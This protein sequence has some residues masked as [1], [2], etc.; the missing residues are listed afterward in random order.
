[1]RNKSVWLFSIVF[2]LFSLQISFAQKVYVKGQIVDQA[3]NSPMIGVGVLFINPVDTV[4]KLGNA[5]D[6]D[7]N[8]KIENVTSGKYKIKMSYIGYDTKEIEINVQDQVLDLGVIK[9]KQ[10][11]VLLKEVVVEGRQVRAIQKGDT[12]EYNA[13]AF[14]TKPDATVQDLVTKMPGVTLENGT[15]KAQGEAIKKVLIDGKEYFGEDA[16]IA[17]KN[18]PADIVDKV[19]IF[20]RMSDQA[21]FS[22]FDDGNSQKALNISTKNGMNKGDFGKIYAGYGTNDRYSTGINL[23]NFKGVRK[24]SLIGISNNINQQ[25]FASQDL[26]GVLGSSG[27]NRGGGQGVNRNNPANNF[28][29]GSQSGIT[30]T[31]SL[32]LNYSNEI[33]KKLSLTGSYFFNNANNTTQSLKERTYFL[34]N[35]ANQLYDETSEGSNNNFNHRFNS[36]L[37]YKIDSSNTIIITPKIS[38]Q[39]NRSINILSGLNSLTSTNLLSQIISNSNSTSNGYDLSNDLLFRHKFAKNNRTVSANVTIN[40]NN[41]TS[42]ISQYSQNRFYFPKDSISIIDQFTYTASK[43]STLSSNIIYTEPVGKMGS[44]MFNYSPTFNKNNSDRIT[45]AYDSIFN[46]YTKPNTILSNRFDNTTITQRTGLGYR[47]GNKVFNFMLNANYQNVQMESSQLY[48]TSLTVKR[49]FDNVLPMGMFNYKFSQSKNLRMFY[50]SSTNVPTITQLQ[51]VINNSNP[52]LLSVGN[53]DLKQEFSNFLMIRYGQTN[54]EKATSFQV[55]TNLTYTSNYIGTSTTIA[56]QNTVLSDQVVLNRGSQLSQPV[57]LDGYIATNTF[58]TYGMLIGKLKSNLNWSIGHLYNRSPSLINRATNVSH[59]NTITSGFS[60]GSN[61]SKMFDFTLS[62][63]A[64]YN[65]VQNTIRPAQNNN[66]FYHLTSAKINWISNMGLLIG[67]DGSNMLYRGLGSEFNQNYYLLNPY[68]G[69]KFWKDNAAEIKMTIFD[70]LAQNNS[71]SRTISSAYLEDNRTLVLKRY[72]MFT[73]TYN[74]HKF[75]T[76]KKAN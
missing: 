36:R 6:L 5:T 59:S 63:S 28:L 66:Y 54:T 20:D 42:E 25:N 50:R 17:L 34:G 40:L 49:T 71:V 35:G 26:L 19:Q 56:N 55:F 21:R 32:G 41:K 68:I 14:K 64:N 76:D 43:G 22:G 69:Y 67:V 37:E 30:R 27:Q 10:A 2:L 61:I 62:Y 11:L 29:V 46:D 60:L 18:L 3:D 33:G 45:N 48:P 15:V 70:L 13:N 75:E 16:S 23:N 44:L 38:L 52:L 8:F 31:T 9:L 39:N 47:I 72:F 74:F 57:N 12:I 73:L 7:G 1:M 51:N 24:I 53:P 65:I 58:L 4:L